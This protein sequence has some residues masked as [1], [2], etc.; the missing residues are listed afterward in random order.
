M[1]F[2]PPNAPRRGRSRRIDDG[3]PRI[4]RR[5][6]SDP[7]IPAAP[8]ELGH[9]LGGGG[10]FR[11]TRGG[12]LHQLAHSFHG[13]HNRLRSRSLLFDR[14]IDFLRDFREP[15]GGFGDLRGAA[16]LLRGGR[17]DLLRELVNFGNHVG[18]FVQREAEIFVQQ[19]AFLDH[20]GALFH[21]VDGFARFLL[22]SLDQF[23]NFL[24]GLRGFFRELANFLG[25]DRE[26]RVRA[27]RRAPPR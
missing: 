23:G 26:T 18:D 6:R 14:G 16:R 3:R 10:Q 19:Q 9:L 12:L 22:N 27:R 4:H 5:A 20:G 15:V 2:E 1:S 13:S 25:H 21:V 24:G 17:A 7:W 8:G 11:G